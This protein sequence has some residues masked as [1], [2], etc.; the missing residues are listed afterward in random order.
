MP[1]FTG[2]LFSNFYKNILSTNQPANPGIDSSL[3]RVQDGEG[4]DSAIWLSDDQVVVQPV[5]DDTT[6]TFRVKTTSGAYPLIV[7]ATNKV[8]KAGAGNANVLTLYKEMGLYD[9]TPAAG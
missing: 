1:S 5:N 2:K 7:D 6:A 9:F 4:S 3:A 8:V